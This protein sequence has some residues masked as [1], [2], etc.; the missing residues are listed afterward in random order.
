MK[1]SNRSK[2]LNRLFPGLKHHI[3][4]GICL[5][6]FI[7]LGAQNDIIE[8]MSSGS[9]SSIFSDDKVKNIRVLSNSGELLNIEVRYEGYNEEGKRYTLKGV[10]LDSKKQV[11]AAISADPVELSRNAE[12]ADLS[13]RVLSNQQASTP[14]IDSK[15][16][17]LSI[18]KTDAASS[19][20]GDL[21]DDL[22][23]LFGSGSESTGLGGLS[24]DKF[25][26]EYNKTWRI[27]G[28]E[29]MVISVNLTPIGKAITTRQ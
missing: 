22:T 26:F 20:E 4:S 21:F 7:S 18:E 11:I 5:L 17:S 27:A 16:I 24:G 13:F 9:V 3:L 6:M 29:N 19:D 8:P 15:Y 25:M 10:I 14:Y 23:E 2:I 12:A 28:N 1:N